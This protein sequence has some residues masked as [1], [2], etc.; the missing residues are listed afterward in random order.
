MAMKILRLAATPV[1]LVLH[2]MLMS[3]GAHADTCSGSV[4]SE[5]SSCGDKTPIG[6][7]ACPDPFP[8]GC[9]AF[10]GE[11]GGGFIDLLECGWGGLGSPISPC[12]CESLPGMK[13]SSNGN[14]CM[15]EKPD[16]SDHATVGALSAID[17]HC[18]KWPITPKKAVDPNDKLGTL[19]V[20]DQEFIGAGAPLNYAI[21]FENL[22]TATAPAQIVVVTD[23]LDAQRLDLATFQLGPITF[24]AVTLVPQPGAQ[25]FAG[26]VD[27]GLEQDLQVVVNAALDR[28][29]GL[30]TWRFTSIDPATGQLTD[31]PDAGFLP[32]NVNA[33]AG[34]GSVV[35]TVMPK[36]GLATGTAIRNQAQVIFDTNAPIATPTWLNTVDRDPPV[37]HVAA[38][39]AVQ[40]ATTFPV[41]WTGTDAG[42]GIRDFSVY[43]SDNGGPFMLWQS[44]SI[45]SSAN[46]AGAVGHSY[47]FFALGTDL[48]GNAEAVKTAAEATT[49]VVSA[50]ACA[51]NVSAQLQVTRSG[52]GYNLATQR[53][54]QTV[55]MKNVAGSTVGAPLSLALDNL[56][57]NATVYAPSG[58]TSCAAPAG[59]PFINWSGSLAPGASATIVLQFTNPTK[60][61]ITYATRVLAGSGGR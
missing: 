17:P 48:V 18:R 53:F 59:S 44:Q 55:T 2:A 6:P 56:S 58:M 22:A 32:P 21:H 60:A 20:S 26:G 15:P 3:A 50:P 37:T 7:A 25:A 49:Q 29:T 36:S 28:S 46:F 9:D 30:V 34:E 4:L 19:G 45:A 57:T 51:V 35:F 23:Q 13:V 24:G 39:A 11:K 31:D 27:L 47:G 8:A 10:F 12:R 61:G 14:W 41:Q 5:G 16:C 38:L 1:L 33:P 42:A 54:T 43:V 40:S 52:F